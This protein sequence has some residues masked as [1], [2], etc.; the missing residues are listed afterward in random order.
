MIPWHAI[1]TIIL[2]KP[3]STVFFITLLRAGM[4]IPDD[5]A[6]IDMVK[7][8]GFKQR[9]NLVKTSQV[10]EMTTQIQDGLFRLQKYL[11]NFVNVRIKLR[12]SS[13]AFALVSSLTTANDDDFIIDLDEMIFYCKKIIPYSDINDMYS[14]EIQKGHYPSYYFDRAEIKNFSIGK[15]SLGVVSDS[16]VS[17]FLPSFIIVML[18][19]TNAVNGKIKKNSF[20]FTN[21]NLSSISVVLD[22]DSNTQHVISVDF[23]KGKYL[24]AYLPLLDKLSEHG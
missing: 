8:N 15:G 7:N 19:D 20:E 13:P 23:K 18:C 6:D 24:N 12:R 22:S 9:V 21:H 10:W 14:R 5:D 3:I 11:A 2:T 16:L 4:Y 1:R 17:G